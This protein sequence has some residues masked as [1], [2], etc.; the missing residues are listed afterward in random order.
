MGG[1]AAILH[2]QPQS[3]DHALFDRL[4]HAVR[5]RC[6][7]GVAP[8]HGEGASIARLR[9]V[10][11]D[12]DD[13]PEAAARGSL[14]VA[15][16]GRLDNRE[17]LIDALGVDHAASDTRLALEAVL[18]WDADAAARLLGDFAF[19][20]WDSL[21]RRAVLAR[22]HMGIRP[23]HF[24][25]LPGTTICATDVAHILA[26]PA[27]PRRAN[28]GVVAQFLACA[29]WNG[30]QTLIDGVSRVPPAHAVVIEDGNVVVRRYW[31]PEPRKRVF[32]R[33]DNEYADHCR[34]LLVRSVSARMRSPQPIAATLSGGIDSSS[35]ALTACLLVKSQSPP[36]LFSM[37]FPGR[38]EADERQ[39]IEAVAKRCG[40][41][42]VL[43]APAAPT[44]S[45]AG[46]AAT[47]MDVPSMAADSMAEGM[48][49]HMSAA[50]YRVALTGAG[51]DFVY[52]GGHCPPDRSPG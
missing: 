25:R 47:W 13:A 14:V 5:W 50:G 37:V 6:P 21:R 22:D 30:S 28:E 19:V 35:V 48:W 20:A 31:S 44:R 17:E 10:T 41:D 1:L 16:D 52:A 4:C 11:T 3:V 29:M 40:A 23:L 8:W 34:E 15:F 46:R 24:A 43:I 49:N 36:K 26:H 51:G 32:Y 7:D 27:V 18:R 2:D 45:I 42:P 38:P 9:F 33:S 39:Y 12:G